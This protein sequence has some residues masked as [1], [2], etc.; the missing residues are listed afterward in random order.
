MEL[1]Y[2]LIFLTLS[3]LQPALEL[4]LIKFNRASITYSESRKAEEKY[5]RI[6]D[7]QRSNTISVA[8]LNFYGD[9]SLDRYLFTMSLKTLTTSG[10]A[11][12]DPG[13]LI[14]ITLL[15]ES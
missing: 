3:A 10:K 9:L 1:H 4:Y 6:H 13:L 15:S 5:K 8:S 12:L 2:S 14:R 11:A 7:I